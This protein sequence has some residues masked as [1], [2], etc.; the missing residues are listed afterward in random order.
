MQEP[1][2]EA[3]SSVTRCTMPGVGTQRLNMNNNK[4]RQKVKIEGN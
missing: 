2:V 3:Q 4:V 1:W